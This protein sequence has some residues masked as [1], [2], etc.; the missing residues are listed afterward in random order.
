MALI[1]VDHFDFPSPDFV[2][3]TESYDLFFNNISL[4]ITYDY[5]GSSGLGSVDETQRGKANGVLIDQINNNANTNSY[6]IYASLV[7]PFATVGTAEAPLDPPAPDCDL[8]LVATPSPE[9]I[10]GANDGQVT[11]ISGSSHGPIEYA[12]TGVGYGSGNVFTGLAPGSYNAYAKDA[13]DC[14]Q[15]KLFTIVAAGGGGGDGR[16]F[17]DHFEFPSPDFAG[18]NEVYDI[19]LD[20]LTDTFEVDYTGS[21]S[22]SNVDELQRGRLGGSLIGNFDNPDG[23]VRY[24]INASLNSPF[25]VI[26]ETIIIDDPNPPQTA[27]EYQ[28]WYGGE[29]CDD[30]GNT[31]EV[32]I[33][34]RVGEGS[35]APMLKPLIFSGDNPI[36]IGYPDNGDYKMNPINGSEVTLTLVAYDG[37]ELADLY[38]TDEAEWKV[39]FLGYYNH[40]VF[41]IPD[42]CY[43]P[44]SSKPYPITIRCTDRI[45]MLTDVPFQ[46][47]SGKPFK[48][49]EN[50]I[51]IIASILRKT[52]L[53]LPIGV[54]CNTYESTMDTSD[55]PIEQTFINREAFVDDKDIPLTCSE[56]L[57]S[58]LNRY[59]A[60]LHQWNG[61]WQI[62]NVLEKSR[63]NVTI[64]NFND[65]GEPD[66]GSS[67]LGSLMTVGQ[68]DREIIPAQA[69]QSIAKGIAASMAYY[70]YG[71]P[72]NELVN[73]DFNDWDMSDPTP[74]N[75]EIIGTMS[76]VR[77]E[78][79]DEFGQPTGDFYPKIISNNLSNSFL[80][81]IDG[82]QVIAGQ[83][84]Q[85]SFDMFAY[86]AAFV[87]GSNTP[88]YLGIQ[89]M[90][91]TNTE[92][93]NQFGWSASAV[94]YDIQ[95]KQKD[96]LNQ[97]TVQFTVQAKAVDY[98]IK[99]GLRMVNTTG[100]AQAETSFNNVKLS[101]VST[102]QTEPAIGVFT[103]QTSRSFQTYRKSPIVILHGDEPNPQRTSQI[104]IGSATV[105][106]VPDKWAREG[107]TEAKSLLQIVAN[108]ELRQHQK[109][110]R[111]FEAD[112]VR[113]Y[114]YSGAHID[115][116]T[117]LSV[118]LLTGDYIFL[119]GTFNLKS[120]VHRLRHAQVYVDDTTYIEEA[121]VLDYGAV[122]L[123]GDVSSGKNVG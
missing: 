111:V 92:Y 81:N 120:A 86:N 40:Q 36:V 64:W 42:N 34:R 117:L 8:T 102:P 87:A 69:N 116:N 112:Y 71:Y 26:S 27:F 113:N 78:R 32:Q 99:I 88:V 61:E 52:G 47:T 25:A 90:D 79:L 31:T 94:T 58:I 97:V 28:Q 51:R 74:E 68:Q 105:I 107:I 80:R 84:I 30:Y 37:F 122:D 121:N 14:T 60:R 2:G 11:L 82:V 91:V 49:F 54:A 109:P 95:Y 76:I 48:G 103:R 96:L 119:S 50:D 57:E 73:G 55:S 89:I 17:I 24:V 16:I 83:A 77:V 38:A 12:I 65:I 114:G 70:K 44:Y 9:T 5:T 56:V 72:S 75:W 98:D 15:T 3:V 29:L 22:L 1:F 59:S 21:S 115:I 62:V 85:V 33:Y 13:L 104:S 45:G 93:Y 101:P 63:G 110:Y 118:D 20:P 6:K 123:T 108:S 66:G 43:E 106:Q 46:N 100:G 19:Y 7:A 23:T 4:A 41:I 35:I 39:I 67:V 18:V 10:T 53:E